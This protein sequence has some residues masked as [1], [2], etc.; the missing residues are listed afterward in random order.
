MQALKAI[1]D[2]F[3]C[4]QPTD[5]EREALSAAELI[6]I[7]LSE[8]TRSVHIALRT[9][10]E[11]PADAV[12]GIESALSASYGCAVHIFQNTDSGSAEAVS[13]STEQLL[14]KAA[15]QNPASAAFLRGATAKIIEKVMTITLAHGGA[16]MLELLG[17]EHT[18]NQLRALEGQPP[19]SVQYD[20]VLEAAPASTEELAQRETQLFAASEQRRAARKKAER[21][22]S[23]G[24]NDPNSPIDESQAELIFGKRAS[25]KLKP[26]AQITGEDESVSCWGDIFFFEERELWDK[27]RKV[28]TFY[29]TDYT[30]SVTCKMVLY[31]EKWAAIDGKL[32]SGMTVR[33]HGRMNF[34]KFEDD[35]VLEVDSIIEVKRKMRMDNAPEKRI[36][37]HLHT[38][39]SAM[40]ALTPVDQYIKRA[41]AWGHEAIAITD[42]GVVQAFPNAATAAKKGGY[43]GKVIYGLES[44]FVNDCMP[45]VTGPQATAFDGDYVVFDVET[46]G[47]S[48]ATEALTEIGAARI[49]GGEIVET[50]QTFVNPGKKIPY[51]IV[52]LTGITDAMVADAPTPEEAVARFF[53]FA[54]SAVLAAHNAKFDMSFLAAVAPEQA[55]AATYIDTLVLARFLLPDLKNHKLNVIVDHL[56]VG[57]FHHH[58]AS[59]DAEITARVLL[60]FFEMAQQEYGAEN[61]S[62]LNRMAAGGIDPKKGK[63]YHQILLVKNDVGRKNLYQ[64]VSKSSLEYFSKNPRIPN[65]LLMEHREGLIVGSACEAGEFFCAVLDGRPWGD[66]CEIASFYDY[67]EIQPICNNRFL[68]ENGRVENDQKLQDLNRTIVRL[69]EKLGKPVVATGDVHFID[70]ECEP[71]RR[72]LMAGMGF[73]DTDRPLPLYFKTTEE[74]LEEF[75]YLGAEKAYEVVITNPKRIA[76]MCEI[77]KPVPDDGILHPPVIEGVD[78]E[79]TKR[80]VEK[81]HELY[82]DP[83]PEI[84]E[85]RMQRELDS[86]IK[87]GFAV[88]YIIAQR[89]VSK[90]LS[91]GYLVGSRGSVGSS[92][93]AFLSGI[94]EV[95]SLAPHYIC[96]NCK[97]VEF[98][99]EG[100]YEAGCDL[101]DKVC[102][103]CGTPY[104]KDGFDIPFETFLGFEG[105]KVPDIDLNFSG[106]YQANAHKYTEVLFGKGYVFRAGTITAL[107]DKTAYGLV[108]K[109]FE[110]RG[111]IA[112]KAEKQRYTI[113]C[114]GVRRS[115]GQH[116]GGIV[117]VPKTMDIHDFTPVQRP[118]DAQDVDVVTTHFDYHKIDQSLLKL[119]ILGHDDPT[120]IR[121]LEDITGVDAKTIPFDD[122]RVMSLFRSNEELGIGEDPILTSVGSVGLPE[123]GTRFVRGMLEETRPTTFGE[124]VRIS[125]LSQGT[126]VWLDNAQMLISKG[127]T[128]LRGCICCRD[129]IMNYLISKG[130]KPKTAFKIMEHVR[131]GRANKAGQM[132]PEWEKDMREHDVPDWYIES[133]VKI[134]YMFPKAHAVAY[135][136]MAVRIAWFKLY[137]PYAF[138]ATYFT[139]RADDFDARYMCCGIDKLLARYRELS[140]LPKPKAKEKTQMSILEV[141]YEFYKRGLE[142][143]PMDLYQSHATKFLVTENGLRPPFNSLPGVGAS[144]AIAIMNE[145]ENGEFLSV[146]EIVTRAKVSRAVVDTLREVG[147]L[148]GIPESAQVS[149]FSM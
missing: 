7:E 57:S 62:E 16:A 95:N 81:A 23:A 147:V 128:N 120:V 94:T 79:L 67:L 116:P 118:A 56:N 138:Y 88:M 24:E 91:D 55:K 119:D 39:M 117:V 54:G 48:A 112:N 99:L 38:N 60:R 27:K 82:G 77:V 15:E 75:S 61:I 47:L 64:M 10:Q 25:G 73:K 59:D 12:S 58:R 129:D 74:M 50:F 2:V 142:F 20:G 28:Y 22:I 71:Y 52:E 100:G 125:G 141:G 72:V 98:V 101:P 133:C 108:N 85:K 35:L 42:H 45:V 13:D 14:K 143:L 11:I 26:I 40:D 31:K 109:Y 29:I 1:L 84:V 139:V 134:Q 5:A 63:S 33:V 97:H 110:E 105:D 124:L 34:D 145:R 122:Q 46:T 69:G 44:Y 17:F 49:R 65:S 36:E 80:S 113:G 18:V 114:T 76:D 43:E 121:M 3:D 107:A 89:L 70:P 140:A 30:Y 21:K 37:L 146:D 115:T 68:V 90:S 51:K 149:F 9:A 78:E 41:K 6:S 19:L 87:H 130:L 144:A 53:T 148:E 132:D 92:F 93:V 111:I 83:L 137:Y 106:E 135:D 104:A 126:N 102:P 127:I 96:R 131:K 32:K 86:I 8:A 4:Y 123:F 103:V 136:M 66:L